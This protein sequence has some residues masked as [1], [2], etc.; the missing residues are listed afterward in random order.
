[1]VAACQVPSYVSNSISTEEFLMTWLRYP[2][3]LDIHV[4]NNI[5]DGLDIIK[6]CL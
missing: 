5:Q 1:M 3:F 4:A 6:A 2:M